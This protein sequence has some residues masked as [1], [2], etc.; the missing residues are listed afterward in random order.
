MIGEKQID[1]WTKKFQKR[2]KNSKAA[3]SIMRKGQNGKPKKAE[4]HHKRS[5]EKK[6]EVEHEQKACKREEKI[7]WRIGNTK[8]VAE[9]F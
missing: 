6:N 4:Q 2:W 5:R 3:V 8:K 7:V 9:Y 1:E